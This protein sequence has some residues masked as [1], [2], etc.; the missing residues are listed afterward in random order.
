MT[1]DPEQINGFGYA[2]ACFG[3]AIVSYQRGQPKVAKIDIE[4]LGPGARQWLMKNGA[5]VEF[6]DRINDENSCDFAAR[7]IRDWL[8]KH[9]SAS[10]HTQASLFNFGMGIGKAWTHCRV[11][12]MRPDQWPQAKDAVHQSLYDATNALMSLSNLNRQFYSQISQINNAI[13]TSPPFPNDIAFGQIHD[14]I[15]AVIKAYLQGGA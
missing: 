13:N 11:D 2:A 8:T 10:A 15:P 1:V 5:P 3:P 6:I 12:G 7:N 4:N 14:L 9:F